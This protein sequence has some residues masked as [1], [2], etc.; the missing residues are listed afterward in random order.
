M[1]YIWYG[2][3]DFKLVDWCWAFNIKN[4]QIFKVFK[5]LK[6]FQNCK[7]TMSFLSFQKY[8][9]FKVHKIFEKVFEEFSI[10]PMNLLNFLKGIFVSLVT[11]FYSNFDSNNCIY[12]LNFGM[13]IV[14]FRWWNCLTNWKGPFTRTNY[15]LLQK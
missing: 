15:C 14:L 1:E 7:S 8:L 10:Y 12:F 4:C 5:K 2:P 6:T 13:W 9:I 11:L 3:C